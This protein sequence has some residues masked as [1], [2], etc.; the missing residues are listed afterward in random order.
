MR[1]FSFPADT[2]RASSTAFRAWCAGAPTRRSRKPTRSTPSRRCCG[3]K[4]RRDLNRPMPGRLLPARLAAW[5]IAEIGR[6]L[7][8]HKESDGVA[9]EVAWPVRPGDHRHRANLG[10]GE[11]AVSRL[12]LSGEGKRGNCDD[13]REQETQHGCF[14]PGKLVGWRLGQDRF[15]L[16]AIAAS[17]NDCKKSADEGEAGD[18]VAEEI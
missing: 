4:A 17:G 16:S 10:A 2:S 1:T 7:A 3:K 11:R 14:L 9:E 13:E 6:S 5:R 8:P 15:A 18:N 12:R